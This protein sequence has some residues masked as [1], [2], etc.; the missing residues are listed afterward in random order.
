MST[1]EVAHGCC[2]HFLGE[3][4]AG[5]GGRKAAFHGIYRCNRYFPL[6]YSMPYFKAKDDQEWFDLIARYPFAFLAGSFADGRPVAT[7]VPM[8]ADRRNGN[9]VLEAHIMRNTD[10]HRAFLENPQVLAVFT[11]PQAYVSAAWYTDPHNASTW[12]YMSLHLAGTIRFLDEAG[13]RASLRKLTLHFEEQDGTSPAVFD[14]LPVE[15]VE[16]M[17]PMITAFEV[18]V[19]RV[20][21][22]FK[23]SQN[24]DERSYLNIMAELG[25]RG[26]QGAAVAAEMEKRRA[27]LFPG[28]A[29]Q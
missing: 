27:A 24:R 18:D 12:N 13:L 8:L 7:Q 2:R 11:G 6:M 14:N 23:L 20:G 5:T 1:L 25:R 4:I 16:E 29:G 19:Q 21:H 26:G 22:T 15:D 10:H 3:V 17:L 9:L 28:T